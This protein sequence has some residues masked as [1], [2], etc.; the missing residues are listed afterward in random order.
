M[1]APVRKILEVEIELRNPVTML[2][3]NFLII[4]KANNAAITGIQAPTTTCV[5]NSETGAVPKYS[6]RA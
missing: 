4:I 2:A 6:K 1:I 3:E 5:Q